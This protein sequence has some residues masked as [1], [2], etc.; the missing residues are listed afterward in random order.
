MLKS[1]GLSEAIVKSI[2]TYCLALSQ[3][4]GYWMDVF[5]ERTDASEEWAGVVDGAYLLRDELTNDFSYAF[6]KDDELMA[7]VALIKEGS[8]H[9][10]MIQDLNELAVTGKKNLNLLNA[11]GVQEEKLDKAAEMS[12]YL[13]RLRTK[14]DE[15]RSGTHPNLLIRNQIF[16]LLNNAIN[17]VRDC[18][19]YAFWRNEEKLNRYFL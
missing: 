4:Q 14:A 7:R 11:V 15:G 2:P 13:L 6:R 3:S 12:A 9:G 1:K 5:K 10:D 17:E 16:M 18:A 8:T 19:R